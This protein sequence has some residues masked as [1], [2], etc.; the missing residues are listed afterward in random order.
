MY[1]HERN[2][3]IWFTPFYINILEEL[4]HIIDSLGCNLSLNLTHHFVGQI[5]SF[6]S[7]LCFILYCQSNVNYWSPP[8]YVWRVLVTR[9]KLSSSYYMTK[10]NFLR[11][12][13]PTCI[14]LFC[15]LLIF[16]NNYTCSLLLL[17][18]FNQRHLI[19]N[20]SGSTSSISFF[21]RFTFFNQYPSCLNIVLSVP[22]DHE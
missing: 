7:H 19:S 3:Y 4:T 1:D 6:S 22:H 20:H 21:L 14:P 2:S 16:L 10:Y 15:N 5:W 9:G 11:F 12:L 18:T 8:A 13:R 17:S